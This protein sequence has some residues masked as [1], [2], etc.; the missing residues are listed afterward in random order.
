MKISIITPTLNHARF[1]EDTIL[2]V[3]Q[4]D[5]K[6]YEHI[7]IDGGSTDGTVEI[8]R[9]YSHLKWISE[10]DSGQSAAINKGF[11]MATGD[12]LTWINSDDWYEKGAFT[13]V[14]DYFRDHSDCFFVYGDQT[15]VDE[16]KNIIGTRTGDTMSLR[17][18]L[19]NPDVVRQPDCFWRKEVTDT[20]GH[21]NETLHLVMDY[22]YFLR[23]AER[24]TFQHINRNLCFFRMYKGAKTSA[25]AQKQVCEI[26][27]VMRKESGGF[28]FRFYLVM[29]RRYYNA[30]K[31][32]I[33]NA[34]RVLS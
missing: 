17:S 27:Q 22:E 7:V 23:I 2:S 31:R 24:Y 15:D 8:L 5:Y 4:Q 6:D 33:C 21:L 29:M 13:A 26:Y 3:L 34:M 28:P 20:V 12:I 19:K 16:Y 18:L 32:V 11:K 14:A 25:L 10:K 9:K 1:I 30:L